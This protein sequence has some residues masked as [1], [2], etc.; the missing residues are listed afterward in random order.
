MLRLD[1]AD[2]LSTDF[3]I[4]FESFSSNPTPRTWLYGYTSTRSTWHLYLYEGTVYLYI[5]NDTELPAL[6]SRFNSYNEL[7]PNKRLYPE[8][9]DYDFCAFLRGKDVNIPFTKYNEDRGKETFY[10]KVAEEHRIGLGL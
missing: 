4:D 5:Y 10:G 3:F 6:I 9:C 7:V 2:P 8:C 1:V